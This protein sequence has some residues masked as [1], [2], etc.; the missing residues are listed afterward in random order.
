MKATVEEIIEDGEEPTSII[1]E[2]SNK[3]DE[4]CSGYEIN[5]ALSAMLTVLTWALV[6]IS[7]DNGININEII[8]RVKDGLIDSTTKL[9]E[10]Q[11]QDL[12]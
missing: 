3:L 4:A 2:L 11:K 6:D 12:N 5:I 10:I 1:G 7:K 8:E 9:I